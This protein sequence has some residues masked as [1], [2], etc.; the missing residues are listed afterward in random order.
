META[1]DNRRVH[2]ERVNL[3]RLTPAYI[4]GKRC[5]DIVASFFGLVLLSGLFFII[6]VLIKLD[7]PRGKVFYSQTRL[8]KNGKTFQ[9]WKFRSMIVNADKMVDQL[10]Q[11]M[12]LK[13]RC[14][15]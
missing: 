6:A 15:R 4:F 13:G 14:S 9:M 10:L 1:S 5:F 7:D 3:Q 11:K 8:G 2:S 12:R